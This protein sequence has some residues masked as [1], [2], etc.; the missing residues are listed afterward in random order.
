MTRLINELSTIDL[1]QKKKKKEGKKERKSDEAP[2]M[3]QRNKNTPS[4]YSQSILI[5]EFMDFL[6]L[7]RS[8]LIFYF[9][10]TCLFI[11]KEEGERKKKEP[12]LPLSLLPP[13]HTLPKTIDRRER[14]REREKKKKNRRKKKSRTEQQK[15][16]KEKTRR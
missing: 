16:M 12:L 15:R 14:E 5:S 8:N 9:N 6:S 13:R 10:F 3:T 4:K 11:V 1:P 7:I 2:R